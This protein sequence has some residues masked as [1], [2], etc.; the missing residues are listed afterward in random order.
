MKRVGKVLGWIGFWI[1]TINML[2]MLGMAYLVTRFDV[3]WINSTV[4]GVACSIHILAAL[5]M[6]VG[7]FIEERKR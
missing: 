3:L 2:V 4:I 1:V 5:L 7:F 6:C